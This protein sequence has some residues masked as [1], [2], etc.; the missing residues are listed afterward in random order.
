MNVYDQRMKYFG[1]HKQYG[2]PYIKGLK[3]IDMLD[4]KKEDDE[5]KK[6]AYGLLKESVDNMKERSQPAILAVFMTNTV[7]LY[8]IGFLDAEAVVNNYTTTSEMLDLQLKDPRMARHRN[9]LEDV[10][11]R[12]EQLFAQSGAADCETI[13]RIFTPQLEEK[14]GDLA[15]LKRVSRL[16]ARGMCEDAELL[17][18]VSEY[19]HNIEPSSSSAYGL[20]RMYLKAK[21]VDKAIEFYNEAVKLEEDKQQK[22]EYYYQLGLIYL[23]KENYTAA[24]ANSL[25]A[26]ENNSAWGAPY[27]LIGKAY[28]AS[29]GNIG[30]NDF[31]HKTAYWAA[32]DKFIKA[33]AADPSV[34]DEANDLIRLYSQHFPATDEIFFR[35]LKEG[36]T[37]TVGGWIGERTAVRGK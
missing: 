9:V 15:W 5:V 21:D 7:A 14:K 32:V 2:T 22:S 27:L 10:K 11:N 33:K 17:Y 12:V 6:E 29:A 31:E 20:A 19:Q 16:L 8:R 24:R 35:G 36:A 34:A 4:F 25:L 13:Q 37:Y 1:D 3:A 30:D 18:K 26:I 23:S 28:A